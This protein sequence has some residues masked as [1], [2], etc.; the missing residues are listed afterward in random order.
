MNRIH[1][2]M[3]RKSSDH[4]AE[5]TET[6]NEFRITDGYNCDQT[7]SRI[8]FPNVG[9]ARIFLAGRWA[10]FATEIDL[11]DI[12][13]VVTTDE[14]IVYVVRQEWNNIISEKEML[15]RLHDLLMAEN[16]DR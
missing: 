16:R 5:V 2:L 7:T 15:S 6:C 8:V 1:T 9:T 13:E 4:W 14:K 11:V 3:G 10:F 12:K